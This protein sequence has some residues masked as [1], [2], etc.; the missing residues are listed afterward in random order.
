MTRQPRQHRA[1][2]PL[3]WWIW[4]LALA[5]AASRTLNPL[6]LGV[7]IG[8]VALVVAARRGDAP[9]AASFRAFLV[10]GVVVLVVRL[11]FEVLFGAPIPGTVVMTLPEVT[12]P[13]WMAGVRLGGEV[14]LEALVAAL[15]SGLQL[16]TILLCVGAANS[17]ANPTRLLKNVP[18]ALYE[19]GVAVVVALTLVPS[20]VAHLHQVR[21]AR[22]LRGHASHGLRATARTSVAVL[23]GALERS[24]SLAAAM[25]S[26]GFG[27]TRVVTTRERHRTAAVT[28]TG[29]TVLLIGGYAL[30]DASTS[31]VLASTLM[32]LGAVAMLLGLRRLNRRALRTVYRP[33]PWR[34]SETLVV[35]SG[36]TTMLVFAVAASVDPLTML[37]TTTPLVWPELP[38]I[39]LVAALVA[40]LPAIAAP[41]L[42][43]EPKVTASDAE[44]ESLAVAA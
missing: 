40:A 18:G 30:L 21:D 14:T 24:L 8:V 32:G 27:R 22:R 36:V 35:A 19:V 6:L 23:E 7:I 41:P 26:R 33:D 13:E 29:L 42:P 15:Y 9:W 44:R 31:V 4:A 5:V 34:I 10:L 39:P 12:L 11:A 37:P 28:L 38:L 43:S 3:A 16:F 1:L 25:D 17:L 2:H 20:A